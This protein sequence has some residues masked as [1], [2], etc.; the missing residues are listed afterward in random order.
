LQD[1]TPLLETVVRIGLADNGL[2]ARFVHARIEPKF[3]ATIGVEP[4]RHNGCVY[5]KPKRGRNG[6]E[7]RRAGR[8]I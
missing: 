1:F 7:V 6:G 4:W 8:V 2:R 5:R 3:S